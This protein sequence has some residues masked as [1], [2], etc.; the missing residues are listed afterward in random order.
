MKKVGTALITA[1]YFVLFAFILYGQC[2]QIIF[3][4]V[5]EFRVLAQIMEESGVWKYF[6]LLLHSRFESIEL[7]IR[8]VVLQFYLLCE[9]IG[10][11]FLEIIKLVDH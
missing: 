11:F 3:V 4:T 7:L 1:F 6:P 2:G 8:M 9:K 10:H 5:T